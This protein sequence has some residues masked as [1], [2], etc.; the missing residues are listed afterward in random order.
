MQYEYR[1]TPA[2]GG[3]GPTEDGIGGDADCL[4]ATMNPACPPGDFA[5]F[6]FRRV[7][8]PAQAVAADP[9]GGD[10]TEQP[11]RCLGAE[12][13]WDLPDLTAIA[14]E[15]LE[16]R[17]SQPDARVEPEVGALVN[18]PVIVHTTPAAEVGFD[19]TQPFPGRLSAAP[20]Y[21]W[22]FGEGEV[23][24]GPGTP[25]DGTSPTRNPGYYLAHTYTAPGAHEVELEMTW[26]ATFTVAGFTI[27]LEDI[28]FTDSAAVQVRSAHSEL[29]D[30]R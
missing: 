16:D 17:V 5:M 18:L 21:L 13:T 12:E 28:V 3:N 1:F 22:N 27:P 10:W 14:R 23:L 26:T 30:G 2:C 19:V 9:A 24:E 29:V 6:A 4:G 8:G 25:Y 11:I 7:I 20:S 15:Y